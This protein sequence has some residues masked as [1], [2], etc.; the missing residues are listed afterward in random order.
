MEYDLKIV[1]GTVIDGTGAER[2]RSDVGI[3]DG[4]A[5]IEK[6]S[7]F[8]SV[9]PG[10]PGLLK[11]KQTMIGAAPVVAKDQDGWV[12]D[13]DRFYRSLQRLFRPAITMAMI[14]TESYKK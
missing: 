14:A 8:R 9:G 3:R 4:R 12:I 10:G 13:S 2:E 6:G 7:I 11:S 5:A 1:G